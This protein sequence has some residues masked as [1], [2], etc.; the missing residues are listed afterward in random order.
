MVREKR[1]AMAGAQGRSDS[2]MI[3]I[4]LVCFEPQILEW[5]WSASNR[6]RRE[7]AE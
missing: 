1:R 2:M 7:H 4:R 6:R 5:L 3:E